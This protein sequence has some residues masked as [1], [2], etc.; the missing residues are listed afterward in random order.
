MARF[1]SGAACKTNE[2]L[3]A[4]ERLLATEGGPGRWIVMKGGRRVNVNTPHRQVEGFSN[5]KR[6]A[7]A[8]SVGLQH[9]KETT[10]P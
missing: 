9:A 10:S 3:L 8:E 5:A 4:Y 1:M 7:A 6:G 2:R